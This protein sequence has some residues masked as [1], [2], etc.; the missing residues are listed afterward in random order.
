MSSSGS[1]YRRKT[2]PDSSATWPVTDWPLPR[3]CWKRRSE[4][5]SRPAARASAFIVEAFRIP[6]GS[7][8]RTLLVGDFLLVNKAVY[9]A[10]V[11]GTGWRIP[12]F[13]EPRRR[14]IV[15]FTNPEDGATNYVKR[16]VGVPGDTLEMRNGVLYVNGERQEEPYVQ[17]LNPED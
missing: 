7:M 6:T 10:T 2:S 11:P 14:D 8:E 13:R 15:V 9:G 1:G 5:P 3:P 17:R 16:I 4:D 12:G